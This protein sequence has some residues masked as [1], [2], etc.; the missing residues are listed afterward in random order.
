[1][2]LGDKS[3]PEIE[4][5]CRGWVPRPGG[6]NNLVDGG[7]AEDL[8]GGDDRVEQVDWRLC[9]RIEAAYRRNV[10]W[11][12]KSHQIEIQRRG[13][14]RPVAAFFVINRKR[15]IPIGNPSLAANKAAY[16][17]IKV[18]MRAVGDSQVR[19]QIG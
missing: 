17:R 18:V 2:G 1:M 16:A 6:S 4:L 11:R 5:P 3:D 12:H 19:R 8:A 9:G 15:P 14:C 13:M 7:R 10:R